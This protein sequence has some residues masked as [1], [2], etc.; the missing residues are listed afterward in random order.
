MPAPATT[1]VPLSGEGGAPAQNELAHC[2]T[3]ENEARAQRTRLQQAFDDASARSHRPGRR[4][5]AADGRHAPLAATPETV[6]CFTRGL[7]DLKLAWP[8]RG[9]RRAAGALVPRRPAPRRQ[10]RS[11]TG[12][13]SGARRRRAPAVAVRASPSYSESSRRRRPVSAGGACAPRD[14]LRAAPVLGRRRP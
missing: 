12:S 2:K 6:P 13:A 7:G 10:G 9:R 8:R 3:L 4:P 5:A 11:A 14:G 1:L